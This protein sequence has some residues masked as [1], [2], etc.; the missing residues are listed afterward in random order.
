[1][2][3]YSSIPLIEN[4]QTGLSSFPTNSYIVVCPR[5]GKSILIDAPPGGPTIFRYLKGTNIEMVLLTHNHIDHIGGLKALRARI[6]AP[7]AIHESDIKKWLPW[8]P[9]LTIRHN[10]IVRTGNLELKALHTPGHTPG[11]MCFKIIIILYRRYFIR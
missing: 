5:T 7:V 8:Q 9:E 6:V 10:Q 4:H 1:M 3:K 2:L 11:S